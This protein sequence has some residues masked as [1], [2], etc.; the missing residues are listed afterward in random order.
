MN[1]KLKGAKI[2]GVK[3]YMNKLWIFYAEERSNEIERIQNFQCVYLLTEF[4]VLHGQFP[5]FSHQHCPGQEAGH[6]TCLL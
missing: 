3:V 5:I 6:K 2:K 1:E 4:L